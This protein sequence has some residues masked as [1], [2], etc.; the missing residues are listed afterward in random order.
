MIANL[1]AA[2]IRLAGNVS[3]AGPARSR[4]LT[5]A[6]TAVQQSDYIALNYFRDSGVVTTT[7]YNEFG[8]VVYEN[9]T[10]SANGVVEIIDTTEFESGEYTIVLTSTTGL[11]L[12]G[13]FIL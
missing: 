2:D 7:I 11:N 12:E 13:N 5:P 6:V 8:E 10:I 3:Q 4:A 9:E 1:S